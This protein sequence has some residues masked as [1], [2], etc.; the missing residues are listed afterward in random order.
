MTLND[1]FYLF[2]PFV[3]A[4]S[5]GTILYLHAII[6]LRVEIECARGRLMGIKE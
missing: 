4:E 2:T 1:L 3:L 6:E 5:Y